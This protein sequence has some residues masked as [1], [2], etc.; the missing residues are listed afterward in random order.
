VLEI[1]YDRMVIAVR[2]ARPGLSA[3]ADPFRN[4][5]RKLAWVLVLGVAIASATIAWL[6]KRSRRS[7][8]RVG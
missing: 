7:T 1:D 5:E 4:P 6:L 3:E 8:H 2:G